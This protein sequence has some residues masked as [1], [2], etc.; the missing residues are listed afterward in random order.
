[1][2]VPGSDQPWWDCNQLLDA[3]TKQRCEALRDAAHGPANAPG[4]TLSARE[5]SWHGPSSHSVPRAVSVC[6][7]AAALAAA[8]AAAAA[9]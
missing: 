7:L 9:H 3:N 5:P 1:M 2:D 6:A 8:A 4:T